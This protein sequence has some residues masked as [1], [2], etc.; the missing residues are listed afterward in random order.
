MKNL[1]DYKIVQFLGDD[2]KE[3]VSEKSQLKRPEKHLIDVKARERRL[4]K[5]DSGFL[6]IATIN[7]VSTLVCEILSL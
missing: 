3:N 2:G 7:V 1:F 5:V 6:P 4:E